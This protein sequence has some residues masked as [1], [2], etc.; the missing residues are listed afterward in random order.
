MTGIRRGRPRKEGQV[1]DAVQAVEPAADIQEAVDNA[2]L[3]QHAANLELAVAAFREHCP[4]AWNDWRLY[5]LQHGLED[6][7]HLLKYQ[8][9][10]K[11]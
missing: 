1:A 2:H 6:M 8:G 11:N 3:A 5:P 7:I 9:G 4:K 10:V